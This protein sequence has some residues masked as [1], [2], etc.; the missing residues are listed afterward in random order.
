M[1]DEATLID[2]DLFRGLVSKHGYKLLDFN[3]LHR[4]RLVKLG[5][6]EDNGSTLN[7]VPEDL[8]LDQRRRF[9]RLN[10]DPASITLN[11]VIDTNNR[12]LRRITIG[13]AATEKRQEIQAKFMQC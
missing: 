12:F 9:S 10:I 8:T 11:R 3:E 7:I 2:E 6:I 5:I 4:K 1:L 13:L